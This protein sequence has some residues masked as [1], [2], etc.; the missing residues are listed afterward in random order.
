MRRLS[1]AAALLS[2]VP[3]AAPQSEPPA[4]RPTAVIHLFDGKSLDAFETWLVDFKHTD[5]DRVFTVVD[6]VDDAPAIRVSGQH[7]GGLITKQRYRDYRLVVEYRWGP[8]TWG[9]RRDRARDNGVLL[10]CQGRPG[11]YAKDFNGPWMRSI[12]F[13]IIEGGVGDIILVGGYDEKG[14][15]FRPSVKARTRTDRNG[16]TVFDPKGEMGVHSTRRVNWW[17]RSEDWADKLGVRGPSDPD[18]PGQEWT[19]IEAVV[20]GANLT[21][22]VNGKLVNQASES[23]LQEGKLLF[24]SEGAELYFRKI[25]LEPLK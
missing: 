20:D 25:D 11:N 24:Q 19:R 17:G 9:N 5:P 10:H 13:Q 22:Y 21:Y 1:Y 6:R 16:G 12:E 18:S 8:A 15:L 23:S 4:I 14:E 3:A 7:Y 2:I